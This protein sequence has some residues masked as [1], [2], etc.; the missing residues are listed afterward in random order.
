MTVTL[1][2]DLEEELAARAKAQ[3]L[4]TEEFVNRVLE[5]VIAAESLTTDSELDVNSERPFYETATP[6]EWVKAFKDWINHFPPHPVLS[7]EAISRES[8]YRER[9]DAQL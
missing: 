5:K 7:D 8:I 4:T 3:G 1:K 6:E 2:P 9:E